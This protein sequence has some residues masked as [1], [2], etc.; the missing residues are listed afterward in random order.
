MEQTPEFGKLVFGR[1]ITNTRKFFAS[2]L[3]DIVLGTACLFIGSGLFWYFRGLPN[4]ME[5]AVSVVAFTLAPFGALLVAV[6]FWNLWLAPCE[7]AYQAMEQKWRMNGP[8]LCAAPNWAI[9]KHREAY[10]ISEFAA[11]LNNSDPESR[12][13]PPSRYAYVKLLR[14]NESKSA[15]RGIVRS[16]NGPGGREGGKCQ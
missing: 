7:L 1:T 4:A 2:I 6:F 14:T 10:T 12:S 5:Q 3:R 16:R 15:G 9:W 11:L 8:A 13:F